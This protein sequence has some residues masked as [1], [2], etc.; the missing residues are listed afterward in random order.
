MIA[1]TV[2][3][4]MSV[5]DAIACRLIRYSLLFGAEL[6]EVM[7]ISVAIVGNHGPPAFF[8]NRVRTATPNVTV[9]AAKI[10]MI[11]H[12]RGDS[13]SLLPLLEPITFA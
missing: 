12:L 13:T 7:V 5:K 2:S 8:F 6:T 3:S 10:V 9:T 4:S 11:A 1:M